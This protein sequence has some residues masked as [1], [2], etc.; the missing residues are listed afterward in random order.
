MTQS[1]FASR[2]TDC[3]N[4]VALL[5]KLGGALGLEKED[6]CIGALRLT[7]LLVARHEVLNQKYQANKKQLETVVATLKGDAAPNRN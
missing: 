4:R 3:H 1:V 5:K 6:M 7:A 2:K